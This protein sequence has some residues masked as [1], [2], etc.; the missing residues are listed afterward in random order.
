M[1][2]DW[3]CI[4]AIEQ[5]YSLFFIFFVFSFSFFLFFSF[6]FFFSF[7]FSFSLVCF[8]HEDEHGLV[9]YTRKENDEV[10]E[11]VM[12]WNHVYETSMRMD[13]QAYTMDGHP[14]VF[15]HKAFC[16]RAC[17]MGLGKQVVSRTLGMDEH[18]RMSM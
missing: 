1:I 8:I 6:V 12:Q 13:E 2:C 17:V 14:F 9:S 4:H 5:H 11:E 7:F 18:Y 3:T 15:P 16:D 10:C